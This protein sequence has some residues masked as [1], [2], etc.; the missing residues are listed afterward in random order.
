MNACP[1]SRKFR[2][3]DASLVAGSLILV[4]AFLLFAHLAGG[5]STSRANAVAATAAEQVESAGF[6]SRGGEPVLGRYGLPDN[7]DTGWRGGTEY[8]DP[9]AGPAVVVF[10]HQPIQLLE[11]DRSAGDRIRLGMRGS[12]PPIDNR[13]FKIRARPPPRI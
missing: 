6:P 1:S 11:P 8:P 13:F 5:A 2:R 4:A 3:P 12:V 7:G 9:D 10:S